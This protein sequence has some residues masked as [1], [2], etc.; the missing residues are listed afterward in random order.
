M[1][2]LLRLYPGWWRDRYGDEMLGL[3]ELAPAR[4]RD[5]LDLLRGAFDAWLHPPTRSRIPALT[6]LIGGGLW[7]VLAAGVVTQPVP[8]DWPG[9]LVE[10]I[11][12]AVT[13]VGFLLIALVGIAMRAAD[14]GG[15]SVR[16][17]VGLAVIGYLGWMLALW[18]TTAGAID[19]ATLGAA[20]G[21]ALVATVAIGVVCMRTGDDRIGALVLVTGAA[22]LVPW[23]VMWLV[24]G[25]AWTA[26]GIVLEAERRDRIGGRR[27]V[28]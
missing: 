17:A 3:L 8:P 11:G 24:F 2:R 28:A 10:V 22:M 5:Q 7:T 20:Q 16:L 27:G 18:A 4:P 1:T 15:R 13:S 6:A 26:I 25:A 23:S 14:A 12:L 19:A 21:F 9:Y